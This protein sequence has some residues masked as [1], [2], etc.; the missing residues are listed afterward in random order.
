MQL[1]AEHE[2]EAPAFPCARADQ[3]IALADATSNAENQGP[4]ELGHC[5]RQH[6]RRV[7]DDDAAL[8]RRGDID[9]VVSD[10]DSRNHLERRSGSHDLRVNLVGQH[11]DERVLVGDAPLQFLARERITI[12]QIDGVLRLE[13]REDR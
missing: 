10:R 8:A 1:G 4:G 3:P 12:V 7:R 11:A 9:I 5:L 2:I 6:I 13:L